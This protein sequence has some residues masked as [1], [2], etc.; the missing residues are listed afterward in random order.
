MLITKLEE[1]ITD[2]EMTREQVAQDLNELYAVINHYADVR[3]SDYRCYVTPQRVLVI[4]FLQDVSGLDK[5][6]LAQTVIDDTQIGTYA[7]E[8]VEMELDKEAFDA[9]VDSP[10]FE[11]RDAIEMVVSPMGEVH[12]H[13]FEFPGDLE[14]S[15]DYKEM[16]ERISGIEGMDLSTLAMLLGHFDTSSDSNTAEVRIADKYIVANTIEVFLSDIQNSPEYDHM[17]ELL[18]HLR[19]YFYPSNDEEKKAIASTKDREHLS[20]MTYLLGAPAAPFSRHTIT[21]KGKEIS[22]KVYLLFCLSYLAYRLQRRAERSKP[23]RRNAKRHIRYIKE[24][25]SGERDFRRMTALVDYLRVPNPE[26]NPS[27]PTQR[28]RDNLEELITILDNKQ[29]YYYHHLA[30]SMKLLFGA[31][32]HRPLNRMLGLLGFPTIGNDTKV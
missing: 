11:K 3:S 24:I 32:G 5:G 7:I 29:E 26:F 12:L 30:K 25:L 17:H 27:H 10:P 22:I 14:Q 8:D 1:F 23:L 15:P 2:D 4:L 16:V 13:Q 28:D 20:T 18:S 6:A 19:D 9:T 21:I 31:N